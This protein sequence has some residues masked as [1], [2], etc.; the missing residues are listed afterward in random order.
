MFIR[1]IIWNGDKWI[2]THLMENATFIVEYK[3]RTVKCV[4]LK[5]CYGYKNIYSSKHVI[6]EVFPTLKT[7]LGNVATN[8]T[9]YGVW[10]YNF[11]DST[12][13]RK[14]GCWCFLIFFINLNL[15]V[16][17]L[18]IPGGIEIPSSRR[19]RPRKEPLTQ[20]ISNIIKSK[21]R[22]ILTECK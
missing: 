16:Y 22:K 5:A 10:Y 11:S 13:K 19:Y 12:Y 9:L 14:I 8:T 6:I 1:K 7:R 18:P 2:R 21:N 20:I 4:T 3:W 17:H 15:K